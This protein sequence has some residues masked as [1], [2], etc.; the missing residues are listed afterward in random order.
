[1]DDF[2]FKSFNRHI[3]HN[4]PDTGTI[5]EIN[6]K[7]KQAA[8][9]PKVLAHCS[10]GRHGSGKLD[11][12]WDHIGQKKKATEVGSFSYHV[13]GSGWSDNKI[14]EQRKAMF[15]TMGAFTSLTAFIR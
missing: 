1:M 13:S 6:M 12:N 11:R 2:F 7:K 9:K 4:N 10:F 8:V 3:F 15:I 5:V 14:V